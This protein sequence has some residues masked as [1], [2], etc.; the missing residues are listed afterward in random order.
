VTG[1]S[2]DRAL[3]FQEFN[4]LPW[5]TARANVELGL[6]LRGVAADARRSAATTALEMVGLRPFAEHFPHELSGGMKQRVGLARALCVGPRHLLMDEP[7]G[8]L[9]LQ[10]RELMQRAL[11]RLLESAHKTVLF[12]THS[13]D[14]AIFLSDRIVVLSACPSRVLAQVEVDLPRPRADAWRSLRASRAVAGHRQ[15]IW[16]LLERQQRD[17]AL[18]EVGPWR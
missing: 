18:A 8:A 5:R 6:E 4:L 12:V 14:E 10:T 9:D 1:P 11:A 15:M 13:V 17:T 2:T 16:D 3:V 7:F